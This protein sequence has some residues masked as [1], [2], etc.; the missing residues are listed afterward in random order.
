MLKRGGTL[1]INQSPFV[2]LTKKKSH[3]AHVKFDWFTAKNTFL[4][5]LCTVNASLPTRKS[6]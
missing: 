2:E 1:V 4:T 5:N 6:S 3:K